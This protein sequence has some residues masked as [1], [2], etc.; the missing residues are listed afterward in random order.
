[1]VSQMT[2]TFQIFQICDKFAVFEF[3]FFF[4]S[5]QQFTKSMVYIVVYVISYVDYTER[6]SAGVGPEDC[7]C[8]QIVEDKQWSMW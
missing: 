6:R 3:F 7:S 8:Q 2:L 5:E 4:Q 1:M